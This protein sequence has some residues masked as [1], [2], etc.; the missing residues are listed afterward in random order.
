MLYGLLTSGAR[1]PL[2]LKAR[3][4]TATTAPTTTPIAA[5]NATRD[6]KPITPVKPIK[7]VKVCVE[8][9]EVKTCQANQ[10]TGQLF[11]Q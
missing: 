8:T 7:P 1:P 10:F 2:R 11:C 3:T 6:V 5:S 4:A 9:E